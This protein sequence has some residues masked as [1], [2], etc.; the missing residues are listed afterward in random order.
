MYYLFINFQTNKLKNYIWKSI[1]ASIQ[2]FKKYVK[3]NL[4]DDDNSDL[5]R[6]VNNRKKKM[7]N[8]VFIDVLQYNIIYNVV[9]R[10]NHITLSKNIL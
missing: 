5:I 1:K 10:R 2:F 9:S 8:K 6:I 4:F 3:K 7:I